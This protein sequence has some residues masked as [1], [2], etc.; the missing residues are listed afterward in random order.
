MCCGQRICGDIQWG[1]QFHLSDRF[2]TLV[3]LHVSE[4]CLSVMSLEAVKCLF[5]EI[6][7]S[8]QMG[9]SK[10]GITLAM[11]TC[12]LDESKFVSTEDV[13]K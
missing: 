9:L 1:R 2:V 5:C 4:R 6:C 8:V 7:L 13:F 11:V 3:A 12:L 10:D